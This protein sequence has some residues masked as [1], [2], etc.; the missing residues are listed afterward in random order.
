MRF[1]KHARPK[2]DRIACPW[3]VRRFVD[4]AAEFHFVPP[5]RVL[6]A[7]AELD[8]I[9]FDVVGVEL[10]HAGGACSFDAFLKRYDL[11]EPALE[12]LAAIVRAADT[13]RLDQAPEAA[14]LL[15][16]SLGLARCIDRDQ[17]LLEAGMVLYDALYAWCETQPQEKH[18]WPPV[19]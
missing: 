11:R 14:G 4:P 12:R 17:Q 10:S 13:G 2:I 15:A 8:A 9:P 19:P 7:A 1:V 16:V 3:L 18:S 5:E 6:A